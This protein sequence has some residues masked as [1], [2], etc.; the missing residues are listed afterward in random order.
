MSACEDAVEVGRELLGAALRAELVGKR[1]G[2]R[3]EPGDVR[4][5]RGAAHAIGQRLAG[6]E[7]PAAVAG[8][9]GL[10]AVEHIARRRGHRSLHS[11]LRLNHFL[12]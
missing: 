2:Q 12:P 7:R 4:E 3:R 9:V 10:Q 8:D 11:A 1:L 5:Q 6:G